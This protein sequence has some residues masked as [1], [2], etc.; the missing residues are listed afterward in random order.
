[1]FFQRIEV[2]G[3][4]HYSYIIGSE[5]QCAVIDPKR[6]IDTYFEVTDYENLKI[7]HIFETHIHADFVSGA[8]ELSSK[9]K[10]P[11]YAGVHGNLEFEHIPLSDGDVIKIGT[12]AIEALHT[13]GHTPEHISYLVKDTNNESV[14]LLF[15]G[16]TLFASE[17]G[18]PDLLG[19]ANT[20]KLARQLY[21]SLFNKLL[22]L[23]DAVQICPGHG[24]GSLCGRSIGASSISTIGQ[25]RISNYALNV[26]NESEFIELVTRNL[27]PVPPYFKRMKKINKEG[28]QILEQLP[29]P[30]LLA[31]KE[32][33]GKLDEFQIIDI[34]NVPFF[35]SGHLKDSFNIPLDPSFSSWVGWLIDPDKPL[36]LV[37][38]EYEDLEG[39]I[40]QLIR[41]GYEN[42][43]GCMQCDIPQWQKLGLTIEEV[44]QIAVNQLK[45]RVAQDSNLLILD[46]REINEWE[47][48]RIPGAVNIPLGSL[49]NRL[50]ELNTNGSIM[51][52]CA[53]GIRS[54]IASSLL[55]QHGFTK[56]ANVLGGTKAWEVAGFEIDR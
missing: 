2:A 14:P 22:K 37:I 51:A 44:E 32:L 11:I 10:A 48:G 42:I 19:A 16:D 21:D 26:K 34:R 35:A 20:E 25:E 33:I 56:V 39:A 41:T 50:S 15:T 6:D 17:V 52:V 4:A 9:T 31:P 8:R 1:M 23:D 53:T 18:R 36:I 30:N 12:L 3:L 47:N 55:K 45:Q 5:G 13:P 28:P 40:R 29:L 24:A 27:P 54:C 43:A 7:T 49:P 46:V 38:D